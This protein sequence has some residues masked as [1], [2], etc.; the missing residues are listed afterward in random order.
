MN[1]QPSVSALSEDARTLYRRILRS[2]PAPAGEFA[3]ALGWPLE[4]VRSTLST[5]QDLDLITLDDDIVRAD[6]PRASI[7][8]LLD[9]AEAELDVRRQ[10]LV[11]LRESLE[12]YE[13]DFRRGLQL[14]GPRLP[15]FE[16]VPPASAPE[17]VQTLVRTSTGQI[18]Q[19]MSEVH[20]GPMHD[21]AVKRY[22]QE[23]FSRGREV[24][25]IF[26]LNVLSDPQWRG[27]VEARAAD[28]EHQRFLDGINLQFA[29]FGRSSLIVD[30]G[31]QAHSYS[32]LIRV[33]VIIDI[34]TAL[35][36]ELWRR[37]ESATTIDLSAQTQRL[38]ELLATGLKD[39][40]IAR[41]LG[42]GLRTVRRRI[43]EAMDEHGVETRFQLGLAIGRRGLIDGRRPDHR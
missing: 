25:T 34:F 19:L 40:A 9:R 31:S 36:E 3:E 7:G 6:D 32:L 11:G 12:S 29:V 28:G 14:S 24:R 35:F 4:R 33:P 38:L 5:L 26:H 8:R 22:R 1:D 37:G 13:A 17:V 43:S 16:E 20:V 2:V 42:L 39:E 21:P 10:H 30:E 27:Y 41:H 23:A 18:R 15:L